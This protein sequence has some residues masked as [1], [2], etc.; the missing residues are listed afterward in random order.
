MPYVRNAPHWK[1]VFGLLNGGLDLA[2]QAILPQARTVWHCEWDAAPSK[3]LAHHYPDVPNLK[4]VTKVDWSQV[5]PVDILTGGYPCQPFS[6]AGQRKGT[7]DERHLWPYVREAIRHLRPR[8]ALLENVAGHRSLGFDRV[9]G[10]LAEDGLHVRWVSLRA[11]DVGAAHHRERL[12]ICVT[13]TERGGWNGWASQPIGLEVKRTTSSRPGQ[14]VRAN[15]GR[16]RC[17][18]RAALDGWSVRSRLGAPLGSDADGRLLP[19]PAASDA[20]G[21]GQHP[22]KRE[23]HSRQL[24]D[25]ALLNG[26]IAWGAYEP[27]IRR[28]EALTR[29]APSPTEP[30]RN[31]N[32]RLSAR[33]VEWLMMLPAG[34]VTDPAISLTRNEQLKALGN[35]VCPPQGAAALAQ[36]LEM[37]VAA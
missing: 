24:I 20:T 29:P 1:H 28:Q 19:T 32:P 11:S 25:Y 18:G 2:V 12:F 9:L 34:W 13:N 14:D 15:A 17:E 21:G 36:L 8:L 23:G 16:D 27:A 7:D 26:T 37:S 31:G 22:S 35:G 6:A 3:I 33:F 4:D 30:G 5:E 10:D